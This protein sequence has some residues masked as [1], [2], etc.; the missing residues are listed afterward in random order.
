MTKHICQ[1]SALKI[2]E[3]HVFSYNTVKFNQW[4][5]N[6]CLT[7]TMF[8][9]R[10]LSIR[11]AMTTST[12]ASHRQMGAPWLINLF[13]APSFQAPRTLREILKFG[14]VCGAHPYGELWGY[15]SFGYLM[16]I[17]AVEWH[18][19]VALSL[20]LSHRLTRSTLPLLHSYCKGWRG[21]AKSLTYLRVSHPW[22]V[23]QPSL[24]LKTQDK[25]KLVQCNFPN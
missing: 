6:V 13:P 17:E 12:I 24:S 14:R 10:F 20:V 4:K 7:F 21:V 5:W 19:T 22:L 2:G 15:L 8:L 11:L 23:S 3:L 25:H 1:N 18:C 16:V 9:P